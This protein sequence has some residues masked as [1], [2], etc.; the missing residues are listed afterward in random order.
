MDDTDYDSIVREIRCGK[1]SG[2]ILTVP[3]VY[4]IMMGCNPLAPAKPD[5]LSETQSMQRGIP[6][7]LACSTN[8]K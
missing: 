4:E 2:K 8:G 3:Q 1:T 5:G 7:D 6:M